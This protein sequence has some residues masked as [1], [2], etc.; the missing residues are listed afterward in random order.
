[1]F[2]FGLKHDRVACEGHDSLPKQ[3]N[4]RL[5]LLFD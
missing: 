5:E 4:V 1:M 2:L 3:S